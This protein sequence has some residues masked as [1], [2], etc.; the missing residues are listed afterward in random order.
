MI[1]QALANRPDI[2]RDDYMVR[3]LGCS[4]RF[5]SQAELEALQELESFPSEVLRHF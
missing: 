3:S 4:F 5:I 2:V 1:W